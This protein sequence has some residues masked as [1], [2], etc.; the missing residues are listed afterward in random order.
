MVAKYIKGLKFNPRNH[1]VMNHNHICFNMNHNHICFQKNQ[2]NL[3]YE[4][5]KRK[6]S[7]GLGNTSIMTSYI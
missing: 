2:Y 6:L 1:V 7:I 3:A 4:F 5:I